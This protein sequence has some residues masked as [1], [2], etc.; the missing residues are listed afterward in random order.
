M[1]TTI[2]SLIT[3][4]GIDYPKFKQRIAASMGVIAGSAAL[5]CYLAQEG[6]DPG[7][8]PNDIDIFIPGG[9]WGYDI[10]DVTNIVD[11][12]EKYGF[13]AQES[14]VHEEDYES[15]SCIESITS[16]SNGINKI[17]IIVVNC[18][19]IPQ[20]IAADFDL[21]ACICWW[22]LHADRFEAH[23]PILTKRKEMYQVHN[24]L[25]GSEDPK[26]VARIQ[27]YID[28]GF[29]LIDKPCQIL[30]TRDMR[31]DL[32]SKKFEGIDVSDVIAYEEMPLKSFLEA[33][34]Y[35]IVIKVGESYYAF[36]RRVLSDCMRR[37]MTYVDIRIGDVYE[38]PF[39]QCISR[40]G[41][42]RLQ[43]ADYSIFELRPDRSVDTE[44]GVKSLF[45][46]YCYSVKE[47]VEEAGVIYQSCPPL[48]NGEGEGWEAAHAAARA[49]RARMFRLNA[50]ILAIPL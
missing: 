43:Y 2:E 29:K 42:E 48:I 13:A 11:L 12:L 49:A 3:S 16:L 19:D 27:K 25:D 5:A 10:S 23:H 22:N 36:D 26:C 37:K 39:N 15:L 41:V 34:E 38:T 18:M 33:T 28:R 4:Y 1:N 46:I 9:S 35:N 21:S 32:T 24:V 7:F 40:L 20:Y 17:Q 30:Q 47:W 45:H 8:T 14:Y 31:E 6:I 44:K 50:G